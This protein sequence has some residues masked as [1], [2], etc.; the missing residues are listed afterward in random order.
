MVKKGLRIGAL[1]IL[2]ALHVITYPVPVI[3]I[4]KAPHPF[5]SRWPGQARP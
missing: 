2:H 1:G 4:N 3:P 5:E